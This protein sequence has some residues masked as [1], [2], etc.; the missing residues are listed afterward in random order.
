MFLSSAAVPR[1]VAATGQVRTPAG[2]AAALGDLERL[3]D[4]TGGRSAW[5]RAR[6]YRVEAVHHLADQ[7]APAPNAIILDFARPRVRIESRPAAGWRARVLDG[8]RGWRL[9]TQGARR[10][11]PAEVADDRQFWESNVYRTLARLAR[12]DPD[13]AVRSAPDGQLLVL[14]AG[15]PLLSWRLNRAG[16]PIAFTPAGSGETVF[17]P[18]VQSGPLR[19][20]SFSVRDGGRWRAIIDRFVVDPDLG[21]PALLGGVPADLR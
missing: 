18:L 20:P 17:G 6:G 2:D 8:D 7:P 14:R 19:F 16:E 4:A 13:L 12:A 21:D 15:Q 1:A 10:L 5:A 3:L 9:D 11:T